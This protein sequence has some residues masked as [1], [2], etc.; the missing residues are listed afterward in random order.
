MTHVEAL[1]HRLPNV[2]LSACPGALELVPAF[3]SGTAYRCAG[4][5]ALVT[6]AAGLV[7]DVM[8][9]RRGIAPET[10]RR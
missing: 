3:A 5:G 1:T 10:G 9:A 6:I 4:C 8:P 2:P 7:V